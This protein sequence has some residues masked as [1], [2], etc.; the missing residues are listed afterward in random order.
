MSY[1]TIWRILQWIVTKNESL[2]S[3]P[4]VMACSALG[5]GALLEPRV[6]DTPLLP[7]SSVLH[8]LLHLLRQCSASLGLV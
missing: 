5:S 7:A 4:F 3:G 1:C 2:P 6:L 8:Q